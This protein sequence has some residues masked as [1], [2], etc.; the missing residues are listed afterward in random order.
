MSV[1]QKQMTKPCER[2]SSTLIHFERERNKETHIRCVGNMC[3][4][5]KELGY[6][7]PPWEMCSPASDEEQETP[8]LPLPAA[9][10]YSVDSV[11]SEVPIGVILRKVII[12][13]EHIDN[14]SSKANKTLGFLRRNLK[15]NATFI[16][17][18]AYKAF[19][20][21]ILEYASPVWDTHTQKNID[22]MGAV[23]R[24]AA[25]FC[26]EPL[27]QHLACPPYV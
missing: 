26:P 27:P 11:S 12:W 23:Q 18:R 20:R 17:E 1:P 25:R 7:F 24:R 13:E 10:P 15:V 8:C 6:G 4:W 16:K 3:E 22:K 14:L 5:E 9:R 2:S 19:F 21:P